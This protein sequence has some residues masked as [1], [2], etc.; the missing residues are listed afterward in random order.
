MAQLLYLMGFFSPITEKD[1]RETPVEELLH[2]TLLP[3]FSLPDKHFPA[4]KQA[5]KEVTAWWEPFTVVSVYEDLF[6]DE[7]KLI[8]VAHVD[9]FTPPAYQV[10]DL[11]KSLQELVEAHGGRALSPFVKEKYQ[12]H[13]SYWPVGESAEVTSLVLVEHTEGFGVGVKLRGVFPLGDTS[14]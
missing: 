12:P 3:A 7:G 9:C 4:F 6:G 8:P 10:E 13:V 11:H 1:L 2:I 5:V 14:V